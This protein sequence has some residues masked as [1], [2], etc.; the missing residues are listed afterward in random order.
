MGKNL[1]RRVAETELRKSSA[2]S[3]KLSSSYHSSSILSILNELAN[4]NGRSLAI[5]K[6]LAGAARKFRRRN[7]RSQTTVSSQFRI[8]RD[9]NAF[10]P[11]RARQQ[12]ITFHCERWKENAEG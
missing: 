12:L 10:P 8:P 2:E 5:G 9:V 3:A 11:S 7:L 6:D 1:V 4:G